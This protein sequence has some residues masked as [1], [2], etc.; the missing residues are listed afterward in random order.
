MPSSHLRRR[1]FTLVE[2]LVVIAIIGV[3]VALLLPAIQSAREAG[4][5]TQ[6]LNNLRNIGLAFANHL[7]VHG[8]YPTGGW[9]W[10]WSGDPDRGFGPRQPGGWMYNLLPYMEE[11]ALHD[12]GKGLAEGSAAKKTAAQKVVQ[13]PLAWAVCPTRRTPDVFPV[14]WG[15]NCANP[16]VNVAA[17]LPGCVAARS[18]YAVNASDRGPNEHG[19]GGPSSYADGDKGNFFWRNTRCP[20]GEPAMCGI[21]FERSTVKLKD[22]KDG[23]SKTYLAGEKYLNRMK[24][25]SGNDAADNEWWNVGF[26]NDMYRTADKEPASDGQVL[27]AAGVPQDDSNRYGSAHE[28]AFHVVM[29]DASVKRIPYEIEITVHRLL[30]NRADGLPVQ[31][32]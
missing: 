30:A 6:C 12:L 22:V 7:D 5:R 20:G 32:P 24:Y 3:L 10:I 28:Q 21:S 2:L 25:G 15:D 29:A 27:N 8:Q 17:P 18:D 9:G 14:P 11:Q 1:G 16:C 13:T 26:D 31:V 23:V 19:G 4:R